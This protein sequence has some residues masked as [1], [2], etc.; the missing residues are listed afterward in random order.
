MQKR[1]YLP[2]QEG[3]I[4]TVLI[5]VFLWNQGHPQ[6]HPTCKCQSQPETWSLILKA[7]NLFLSAVGWEITIVTKGA[8]CVHNV[9]YKH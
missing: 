5:L 9:Y 1:Q 6:C 4:Q 3:K 7:K 2:F 8:C